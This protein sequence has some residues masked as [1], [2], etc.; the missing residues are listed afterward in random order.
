[1]TQTHVFDTDRINVYYDEKLINLHLIK[2]FE[3][4]LLFLSD[5]VKLEKVVGMHAVGWGFSSENGRLD[6]YL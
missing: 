6:A 4:R 2:Q 1:M 5:T 3:L